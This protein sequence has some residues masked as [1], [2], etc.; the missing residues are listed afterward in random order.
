MTEIDQKRY[1]EYWK[2]K[3]SEIAQQPLAPEQANKIIIYFKEQTLDVVQ[4][5]ED[6]IDNN[7]GLETLSDMVIA[8]HTAVAKYKEGSFWRKFSGNI[9]LP[10]FNMFKGGNL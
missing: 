4:H 9:K 8:L 2:K 6:P 10:D 3:A 1:F 5:C 7:L